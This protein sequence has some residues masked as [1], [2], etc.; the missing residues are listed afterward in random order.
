VVT[1]GEP[2]FGLRRRSKKTTRE[3]SA[4]LNTVSINHLGEA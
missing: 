3:V 4:L 2:R 1:L